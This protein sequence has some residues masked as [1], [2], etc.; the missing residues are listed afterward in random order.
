MRSPASPVD[1][2][3]PQVAAR[4][5]GSFGQW[6]R[7][8]PELSELMRAQLARI[9]ATEGLSKDTYEIATRSLAWWSS[10]LMY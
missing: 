6:K 9:Q 8:S 4:L 2:K 1:K 3:N 7:Y 10:V 5:C